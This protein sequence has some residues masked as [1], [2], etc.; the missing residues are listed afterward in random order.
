MP[1]REQILPGHTELH[2]L[3]SG[4]ADSSIQARVARNRGCVHNAGAQGGNVIRRCIPLPALGKIELRADLSLVFGA[5]ARG[6]HQ[7]G[8]TGAGD[9]RIHVEHTESWTQSPPGGRI[10]TGGEV[11]AVIMRTAQVAVIARKNQITGEGKRLEERRC[12]RV[13]FQVTVVAVE[14]GDVEG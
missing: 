3:R 8:S 9:R 14:S 13:G 11:D 1:G 10:P 4:P 7:L 6:T 12:W 2:M 5:I